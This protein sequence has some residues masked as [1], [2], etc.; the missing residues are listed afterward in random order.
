MSA[1]IAG[2][3]I[4]LGMHFIHILAPDWRAAQLARLGEKAW[5][6]IFSV[7]SLV[8]FGLLVWGYGQARLDPVVLW[9][10]PRE[11]NAVVSLLMLPAFILLVAAYVP[12]N[13]I[14]AMVGHPMVASVKLWAFAHLLVNGNLADVLLFGGFLVWAVMSF[15]TNRKRDRLSGKTYP[16][17][18]VSRTVITV[19][20]GTIVYALFAGYL[21]LKLIGVSPLA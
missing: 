16:V 13:R 1:L 5:K 8:G 4:F 11:L 20:V 12:G 14:K 17:G 6:G 21:H 2:L 9:Q 7:T 18:P 15:V 3:A 10:A 19:V